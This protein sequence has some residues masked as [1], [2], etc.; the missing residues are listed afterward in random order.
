MNMN[1]MK[2]RIIAMLLL[3]MAAACAPASAQ[4]ERNYKY[5]YRETTPG[6]ALPGLGLY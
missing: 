1:A 3:V 5:P 4:T 6:E 2:R